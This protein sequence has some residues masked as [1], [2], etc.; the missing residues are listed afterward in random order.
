MQLE[1]LIGETVGF[2]AVNGGGW[3]P[4][5]ICKIYPDGRADLVVIG[6]FGG[7]SWIQTSINFGKKG[8]PGTWFLRA[9]QIAMFAELF[10][11]EKESKTEQKEELFADEATKQQADNRQTEPAASEPARKSAVKSSRL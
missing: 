5:I 4:A 6:V 11:Q 7:G 1:D 3:Y 10:K 8:K 2:Q 9:P